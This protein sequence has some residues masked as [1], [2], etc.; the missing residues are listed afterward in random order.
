MRVNSSTLLSSSVLLI[1]TQLAVSLRSEG[2]QQSLAPSGHCLQ[3][4]YEGPIE[5][6]TGG[7]D[8]TA[9][10]SCSGRLIHLRA[11]YLGEMG[12]IELVVWARNPQGFDLTRREVQYRMPVEVGKPTE[13]AREA[14]STFVVRNGAV[15][16]AEPSDSAVE[17]AKRIELQVE[18]LLAKLFP[19]PKALLGDR[20]GA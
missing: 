12:Y 7:V 16:P 19:D 2:Q 11:R 17:L 18:T 8:A 15:V 1:A 14:V 10:V 3:V 4:R 5:R 6:S 9:A 20:G 13:V